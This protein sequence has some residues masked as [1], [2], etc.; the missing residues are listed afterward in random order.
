MCENI[1]MCHGL[2]TC[3]GQRCSISRVAAGLSVGLREFQTQY[4]IDDESTQ[5][6]IEQL[7]LETHGKNLRPWCPWEEVV[8]IWSGT[9]K[10][11]KK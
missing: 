5:Q 9:G 11:I 6:D 10:N 4:R 3:G 8:L 2:S 1:G 7:V